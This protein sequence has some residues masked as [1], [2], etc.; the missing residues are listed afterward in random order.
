MYKNL[1]NIINTTTDLKEFK[2]A[3]KNYP[4]KKPRHIIKIYY[5]Y[6]KATY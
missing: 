1:S 5:T 3:L 4:N 6:K 2:N